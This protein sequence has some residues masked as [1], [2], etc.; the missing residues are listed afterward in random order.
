[1]VGRECL[2]QQVSILTLLNINFR[3][4]GI[5]TSLLPIYFSYGANIPVHTATKSGRNLFDI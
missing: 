2:V 4:S 3:L 1:M 5:Q